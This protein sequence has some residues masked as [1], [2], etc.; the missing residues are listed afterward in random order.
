MISTI[1]VEIEITREHRSTEALQQWRTRT[2]VVQQW[3]TRHYALQ[4]AQRKGRW[5]RAPSLSDS[6]VAAGLEKIDLEG[7]GA[8]MALV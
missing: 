5:R 4:G 1:Q 7:D 8:T 3:R 2:N 6:G